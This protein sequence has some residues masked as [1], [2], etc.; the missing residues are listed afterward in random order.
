MGL[1]HLRKLLFHPKKKHLSIAV[2]NMLIQI[3]DI[4]NLKMYML[5]ILYED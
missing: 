4:D 3:L 1:Y 5:I 2:L